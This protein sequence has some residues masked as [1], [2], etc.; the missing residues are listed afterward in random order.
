MISYIT[1]GDP[2]IETTAA[3]M[4]ILDG[5]RVDIIELGVPHSEPLADGPVIQVSLF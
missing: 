1:A 3:A 4:K 5:C 2:D